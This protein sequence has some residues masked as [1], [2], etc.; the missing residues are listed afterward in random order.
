VV[1]EDENDYD[2]VILAR[3]D[4]TVPWRRET[5]ELTPDSGFV[6][7]V[8]SSAYS[9]Q[10][11]TILCFG[12]YSSSGFLADKIDGEIYTEKLGRTCSVTTSPDGSPSVAYS[13]DESVMFMTLIEGEWKTEAI[14]EDLKAFSIMQTYSPSGAP[15]ISFTSFYYEQFIACKSD[16]GWLVEKVGSP[17]IQPAEDGHLSLPKRKSGLGHLGF[18]KDTPVVVYLSRQYYNEYGYHLEGGVPK[19]A[20]K[21]NDDNWQVMTL[22]TGDDHT[23]EIGLAV[24]NDMPVIVGADWDGVYSI[25][26]PP[27]P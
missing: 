6:T 2:N 14:T 18:I 10:T 11:G 24:V 22:A 9:E 19:L 3:F 5:W 4:G 20:F 7:E 26:Y 13:V 12:K 25:S 15:C 16:Q 23:R 8:L 1:Y 21:T 17:P 27:S